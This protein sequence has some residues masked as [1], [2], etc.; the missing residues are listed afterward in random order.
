MGLVSRRTV[1]KTSLLA[2]LGLASSLLFPLP[3]RAA[4]LET[5][6]KRGFAIVAVKE[7]LR[8]LGFRDAAGAL[9][10]FEIDLARQIVAVLLGS[11]DAVSFLPVS[12]RQ[13]LQVVLAGEA[14]MTVAQVT[15]TESRSRVVAFSEPYYYDRT[16]FVSKNREIRQASDLARSAIA[17]LRDSDTIA[18]VR[19]LL[20]RAELVGADSYQEGYAMLEAGKAT[21]FAGDASVLAGWVAEDPDY[22]LLPSLPSAEPLAVVLPKG[23]QYGPLRG[24][25]DGAIASLRASGWLA[26]RTAF[27]G[28][29]AL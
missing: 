5:I 3:Q 7:N 9:Q 20:P 6:E 14:D 4:E 24:K 12:N 26:E 15:V 25:V 23:L 28:L 13:R 8:P 27:W 21:A 1:L 22:R 16:T 19:Y 18:K 10:G 2:G 11:A 29:P 17:L